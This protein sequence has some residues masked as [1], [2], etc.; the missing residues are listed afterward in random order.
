MLCGIGLTVSI[1]I[2]GLSYDNIGAHGAQLLNESKLGILCGSTIS[3]IIGCLL[4]NRYLP[5]AE[6]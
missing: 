3:A 6:A 2:A 5:K 1:F 4:L